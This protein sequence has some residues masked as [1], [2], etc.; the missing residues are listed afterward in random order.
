[1]PEPEEIAQELTGPALVIANT[2]LD[3]PDEY[4]EVSALT[5]DLDSQENAAPHTSPD[6]S[7]G[8]AKAGEAVKL[9]LAKQDVA[10][11]RRSAQKEYDEEFAA[12]NERF[13]ERTG[14][15]IAAP[16]QPVAYR[17]GPRASYELWK[18]AIPMFAQ[19]P[20]ILAMSITALRE[21]LDNSEPEFRVTRTMLSRSLNDFAAK[22]AQRL[23]DKLGI[24]ITLKT[25]ASIVTIRK[26]FI[27]RRDALANPGVEKF[28]GKFEIRGNTAQVNG[29][30][31]K[32]QLNRSGQRRLK[33]GKQW[34]NLEALKAFCERDG[35]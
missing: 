32:V 13:K 24:S 30:E 15:S 19:R 5:L 29:R 2:D 4:R 1:M 21:L 6:F 27:E 33:Q 25:P 23:L 22:D 26:Q 17:A 10:A 18:K 28:S 9:E 34:L 35:E 8:I 31:Y 12:L 3:N 11:Q 7:A 16:K 20:E 14:Y